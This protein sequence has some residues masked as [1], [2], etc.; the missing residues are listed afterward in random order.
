MLGLV[1]L[2]VLSVILAVL[3]RVASSGDPKDRATAAA[4]MLSAR[5]R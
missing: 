2:G 5:V 4:A 3:V 1:S